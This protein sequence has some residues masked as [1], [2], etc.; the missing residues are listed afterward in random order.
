MPI[1]WDASYSSGMRYSELDEAL[2]QKITLASSLKTGSMVLDVGCGTGSIARQF[3][4]QGMQVTGI[5][6][7]NVALRIARKETDPILEVVYQ[8]L[9]LNDSESLNALRGKKY[10]LIISKSTIAFVQDKSTT[11]MTLGGLL[12]PGG[13]MVVMTAIKRKG[14]EY[15]SDYLRLSLW[16]KQALQLF[17]GVFYEVELLETREAKRWPNGEDGVFVMKHPKH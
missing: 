3:A 13:S 17:E 11:L 8:Q 16:L 9:D 2:V 14:T 15:H 10:D 7:S 4:A 5:D 1:D 6:M 12:H